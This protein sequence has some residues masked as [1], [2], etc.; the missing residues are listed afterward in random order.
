MARY[1]LGET[2][3]SLQQ[4]RDEVLSTT[5]NHFRQFADVLAGVAREGRV[6]VMGS[7]GAVESANANP[8]GWLKVQKVL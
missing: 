7:A 8:S 2:E 4:T 5:V 6:V 3:E 1:L